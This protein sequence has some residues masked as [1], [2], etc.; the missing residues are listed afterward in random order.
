MNRL[1]EKSKS[2]K[3][4]K[5]LLDS[6]YKEWA[7]INGLKI[8]KKGFGPHLISK[9]HPNKFGPNYIW[10]GLSSWFNEEGYIRIVD[11]ITHFRSNHNQKFIILEPYLK[12]V[13]QI[14]YAK[15]LIEGKNIRVSTPLNPY[16]S[17]WAPGMAVFLVLS[18]F[19]SE[20][21]KW[22]PD[23]INFE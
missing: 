21:I 2:G 20:E 4:D 17:I 1:I 15:N 7:T 14:N 9:V 16:A 8:D 6:L 23:Q 10:W 22:L 13:D 18:S 3:Y 5:N 12:N 11:H 19:E